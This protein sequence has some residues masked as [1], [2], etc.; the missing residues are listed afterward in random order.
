MQP[1]HTHAGYH[2]F[3]LT[4]GV[5]HR[6]V[7]PDGSTKIVAFF[8]KKWEAINRRPIKVANGETFDWVLY[9]VT[10]WDEVVLQHTRSDGT[11]F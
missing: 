8:P 6:L 3:D 9:R 1:V 5:T 7:Q 10:E 11:P 4:Q 2:T